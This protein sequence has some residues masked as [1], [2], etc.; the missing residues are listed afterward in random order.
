MRSLKNK[1]PCFDC[2]ASEKENEEVCKTIRAMLNK[3]NSVQVE[4]KDPGSIGTLTIRVA[5][6]CAFCGDFEPDVE[7][8][9]ASCVA[10]KVPRVLTTIR[11]KDAKKCAVIYERAKEALREKSDMVQSNI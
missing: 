7:K 6:Y 1:N 9:D 11:C 5:D 3:S 2:L 8:I 4:M 10:D